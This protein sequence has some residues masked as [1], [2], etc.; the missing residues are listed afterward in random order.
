MREKL[1][2]RLL[3]GRMSYR[4]AVGD[5]HN[6]AFALEAPSRRLL[7]VIVSD[8]YGWDHASVSLPNSPHTTPSWEEMVFVR[9]L[10]FKPEETCMELHVPTAQ[11]INVHRSC[12]HLWRP[13]AATIP[14]PPEWMVA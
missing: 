7:Y 12:L 10:V 3:V 9:T 1:D 5:D 8:G 11:H 4:G 6:G 13:Q 14:M 2:P